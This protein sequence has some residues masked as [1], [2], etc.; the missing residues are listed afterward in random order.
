MII[1]KGVNKIRRYPRPVVV[2]GVFDGVHKAHRQILQGAVSRARLIRGKSIVVTFSPHPHAKKSIYSL[3]HRLKLIASSGIDICVVINFSR[4]FSRLSAEDFVRR[5]LVYKIGARYIYIGRNYRFGYRGRGDHQAL[6]RLARANGFKVEI[7]KVLKSAGRTVSSTLL[8]SLIISGNLKPAERLLSRQV[9]VL[10]TVINGSRRGGSLGFPTANID[11]HH[12]VLPPP[13]IYAVWI[14]YKEKRLKGLCYIGSKPTFK[15]HS[16]Q[17]IAHR[18]I[19]IEVYIYNFR[20]NIYGE[21]LEIQFIKKI[22]EDKKFPDPASLVLQ[23]KKDIT[24][25]KQAFARH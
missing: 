12:E 2:L 21:N 17:L 25:S 5:V 23:I 15:A 18:K 20:K 6:L 1:V 3:E 16:S 24:A 13:G 14:I 11:P 22:R 19:S 9:S 7:F 8:R 10:G 4:A